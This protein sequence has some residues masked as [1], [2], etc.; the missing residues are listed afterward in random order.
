[1]G[2]KNRLKNKLKKEL[3]KIDKSV[4]RDK[5]SS[6]A[7]YF[8]IPTN[9]KDFSIEDDFGYELIIELS[10]VKFSDINCH[11]CLKEEEWH[12]TE[13]KSYPPREILVPFFFYFNN[14][15]FAYAKI[16]NNLNSE[17]NIFKPYDAE[18][19]EYLIED[20]LS[21]GIKACNL[22]GY[23][24]KNKAE[25]YDRYVLKPEPFKDGYGEKVFFIPILEKRVVYEKS[26]KENVIKDVKEVEGFPKRYIAKYQEILRKKEVTLLLSYC[27]LLQI[28]HIEIVEEGK[29]KIDV[30]SEK[31]VKGKKKL[32]S[33]K[34]KF[35]DL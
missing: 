14:E 5:K 26:I 12:G 2:K 15:E 34:I 1:M 19:L 3:E 25:V 11:E 32:F 23:L 30:L 18:E 8:V 10:K 33:K 21:Q 20:K 13:K 7:N 17:I 4:F 6:Y 35:Y 29:E 16:P 22:M 31:I 27:P 28:K 24:H 9:E